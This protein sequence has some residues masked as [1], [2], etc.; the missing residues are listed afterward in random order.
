MLF[1]TFFVL[2]DPSAA[3]L[4]EIVTHFH[5]GTALVGIGLGRGWIEEWVK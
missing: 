2:A 1:A 3:S 4:N 5:L